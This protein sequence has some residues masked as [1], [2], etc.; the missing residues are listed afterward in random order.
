MEVM[1]KTGRFLS[2]NWAYAFTFLAFGA[3]LFLPDLAFAASAHGRVYLA[4]G[5]FTPVSPGTASTNGLATKVTTTVDDLAGTVQKIVGPIALL[6]MI[7]GGFMYM[8]SH[9][10]QL[11]SM[12]RTFIEGAI[13]GL[14]IVFLAPDIV[15]TI[16]NF[17]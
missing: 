3:A 6:M 13:I 12:A 9:N 16:G 14:L 5:N 15:N 1:T 11:K 10:P 2:R 7:I 17:L 8:M 4:A